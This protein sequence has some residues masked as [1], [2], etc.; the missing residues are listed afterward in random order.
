MRILIIGGTAF[1]GRHIAQAAVDAGHDLTLFHRGKTGTELFGPATHLSGDRE[2]DLSALAGG[3]WDATIDVCAYFPRQVRA[4]AAAL[5]TRG[6]RYVFISSV[7]AYSPSVQPNYDE[8]AP[9]ADCRRSGGDRG[10]RGELRRP[11]GGLRAG[12]RCTVRARHHDH[13]ADLR[14]RPV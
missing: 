2:S 7:S 4:L 5:G 11:E 8:S 12:E 3:S 6:G 9:L 10:H 1:V 14:D 13:P